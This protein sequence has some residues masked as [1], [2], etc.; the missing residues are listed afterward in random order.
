[1]TPITFRSP[2]HPAPRDAT[3]PADADHRRKHPRKVALIGKPRRHRNLGQ[4][5][6]AD[7]HQLLGRVHALTKQPLV[8]RQ[9]GG[10]VKCARKMATEK[11]HSAAICCNETFPPR[12]DS[13]LSQ[14]RFVCQGARPPRAGWLPDC[15]PP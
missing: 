14:A 1:V 9:A 6:V 3:F 4:R 12:S 10:D 2:A 5:Q 8:R 15:S 7:G 11:S 13:S